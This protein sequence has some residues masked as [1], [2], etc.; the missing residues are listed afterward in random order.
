MD[1][2]TTTLFVLLVAI[3]AILYLFER[4]RR[5]ESEENNKRLQDV[6]RQ[7]D[8][9]AKIIIK[10]DL[11][12]NKVQEELDK[13]ITGL[14]TLH[15]LGK[16]IGST[17]NVEDLFGLIN[18]PL[19]SKLG[20]SRG[21]IM[22]KDK[23]SGTIMVKASIAYS[24]ADIKKIEQ[25]LSK[26]SAVSPLLKKS[27]FLLV[28]R[29]LEKIEHEDLL[30]DIFK[31]DSFLT[32]PIVA[33]DEA[34]GFILM[35]NIS[36]H[37]KVTEGDAELLSILASQIGT[38]IENTGL[39]T[40][41]FDSH[42][43]LNRRVKERTQ[44]LARLNEE[45]QRLNKVKSDFVSAVSHELRTP[46]TSIKGYASI[47]MTGKLGEVSAAQKERLEKIDKHS[48][49]LT[50]L[51]NNLLD[52]ARIE[53]GRVQM[54][55]KEISIKELLDSIIDVIAHQVK[56]KGISLKIN[57]KTRTDKI[58]ADS[59][60]LERVLLNL[61]SNAIK[62]T[63]EKG[64]VTIYVK[65]RRDSIEFSVEDTGIGIPKQDLEK[66][67]E[68][69][70]RSDNAPAQKVQGTGLGLSLVKKIIEAHKGAIWVESELGK[71][72]IF[73]FTIPKT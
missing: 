40:E 17:F 22:I 43:D 34:V 13:K 9:Q 44:E 52:I 53:S 59:G 64:R 24:E 20:F 63:P 47:L 42:Q 23:S 28:N 71:G 57:T 62:F 29:D 21:L 37:S 11:A 46:L 54:E 56:E 2:Y 35:G 39:Y 66:V 31:T 1:L 15:E 5:V 51:I 60:Q 32:V 73:S 45:L 27:G 61:L 30:S 49:N 33:K 25:T 72:A 3:L 14:Y 7:L 68:E 70:F 38:A 50:R 12:L 48:N 18:K 26:G 4:N 55:I 10:T 69:F 65:D 19:V 36:S 8:E 6:I 16:K 58:K 41:L 67:F